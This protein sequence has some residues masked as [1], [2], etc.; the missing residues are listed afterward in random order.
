M[1]VME[2][3]NV[4]LIGKANVYYEG[5]VSS[6][7][8]YLESGERKTLGFMMPGEYEFGTDAAEIMEL[9]G[10]EM[11]VTLAG[12]TVS[13]K[14]CAGESFSVPAKSSYKAVVIGYADYCCSYAD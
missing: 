5:R 12:E 1:S 10:G 11:E 13:K 2:F 3:E 9:L 6:R 8:F 7:T 4:K 14:Y